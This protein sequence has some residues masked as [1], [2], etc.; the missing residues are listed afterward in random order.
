MKR[1]SVYRYGTPSEIRQSHLLGYPGWHISITKDGYPIA[2][3]HAPT[4]EEV[5]IKAKKQIKE[6][7]TFEEAG[8]IGVKSA[9]NLFGGLNA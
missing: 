8:Y 6:W 1:K 7:L 9:V 2:G 3:L 4:C 5:V